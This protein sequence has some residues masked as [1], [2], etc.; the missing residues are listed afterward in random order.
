MRLSQRRR[1]R[2]SVGIL[3]VC[4]EVIPDRS[5]CV[6]GGIARAEV[7]QSV[8]GIGKVAEPGDDE[9]LACCGS[10]HEIRQVEIVI[11]AVKA[12]GRMTMQ[13]IRDPLGLLVRASGLD[14]MV[15]MP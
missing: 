6:D 7:D 4:P 10:R 8:V 12:E 15:A 14:G 5:V 2:I 3:R 11:R 13:C 9:N 1:I